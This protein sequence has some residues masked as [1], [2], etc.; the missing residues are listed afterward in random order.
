[1]TRV[2][3]ACVVKAQDGI[4]TN[5][6]IGDT[7]LMAALAFKYDEGLRLVPQKESLRAALTLS[8]TGR[9]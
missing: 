1:M 5:A 6:G 3:T 4:G 7:T 9:L 2:A 8:W